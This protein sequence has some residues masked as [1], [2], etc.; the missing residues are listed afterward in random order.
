M[1][2]DQYREQFSK[3]W[4]EFIRDFIETGAEIA[5]RNFSHSQY[6]GDAVAEVTTEVRPDG[7]RIIATG[8]GVS[9]IE[10]GA[11][12][13]AGTTGQTPVEAPYEIKPW[14]W[15]ET[16]GTGYGAKHGY[17][18]HNG[19]KYYSQTPTGA[20]QDTSI[21]LQQTIRQIAGRHF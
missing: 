9:F 16:M 19:K 12:I 11:G 15:S 14:S 8:D 1:T 3:N 18:F 2:I 21:E 5:N 4:E 20:M 17:W 13:E 7:G 6:D 10:F